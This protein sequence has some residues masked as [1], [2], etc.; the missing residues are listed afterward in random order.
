MR[1]AACKGRLKV[2]KIELRREIAGRVF[3]ATVRG[4]QCGACGETYTEGSDGERFDLAVAN[5]LMSAEPTGEAFRFLRKMAGLRAADLA[6]LLGVT[7]DTI[8][9]WETGKRPVDR[10]AFALVG[11]LVQD[12]A[13]GS[14]TKI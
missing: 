13:T 9:R 10:V 14:A 8:S 1:C 3:T 2:A 4:L 7:G 5:A 12:Q 11:L 6:P